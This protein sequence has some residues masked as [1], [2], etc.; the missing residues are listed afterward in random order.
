MIFYSFYVLLSIL[1]CSVFLYCF[2]YCFSLC[3]QLFLFYLC[4]VY[5]QL[6]LGENPTAV[7]KNHV[8]LKEQLSVAVSTEVT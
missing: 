2:V 7:N 1:V 6:P 8:S 5:A 3:I 4:I